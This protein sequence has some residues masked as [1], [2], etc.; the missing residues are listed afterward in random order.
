MRDKDIALQVDDLT[1]AEQWRGSRRYRLNDEIS[2]RGS[3]QANQRPIFTS[4]LMTAKGPKIRHSRDVQRL[5][6]GPKS[7]VFATVEE[8]AAAEKINPS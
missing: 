1:P 3:W 4:E 6:T 2:R 8:I 5:A 7:G